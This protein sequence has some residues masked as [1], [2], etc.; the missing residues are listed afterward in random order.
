MS[1]QIAADTQIAAINVINKALNENHITQEQADNFLAN[2]ET[3]IDNLLNEPRR[4]PVVNRFLGQVG[5]ILY[6]TTADA[7]GITTDELFANVDPNQTLNDIVVAHGGDTTQILAD[8]QAAATEAI[9]IQPLITKKLPKHKL[10]A[11]WL[12]S[13]HNSII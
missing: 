7:L 1:S 12:N 11:P 8:A 3:I 2:L 6:Q 13:K 5:H 9:Q 10:T 4:D